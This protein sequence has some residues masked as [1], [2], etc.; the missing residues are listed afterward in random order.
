MQ[1]TLFLRI[2]NKLSETSPYFNEMHDATG[3]IG[4]TPLQKCIIVVRQLAHGMT[5][6]MIDRHLKLGKTIALE[7]LDYYCAGIVNCYG[8][9]F[10]CHPTIAN[11]QCLLAKAEE[12]E[13]SDLLVSIDCMHGQW[14]N[15]SVGWQGQF[16]RGISN[17]LQSLLKLL[18]LMAIRSRM[19]FLVTG[20][21]NDIN[22]LNQSALFVDAIR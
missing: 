20:S 9:E 17:I 4:L 8:V 13:F 5:A 6:D 15:C 18:L 7:C 22:M 3:Y 12:R 1:R 14:H 11:T 21:N 19:P 2:V 16:T 10:L